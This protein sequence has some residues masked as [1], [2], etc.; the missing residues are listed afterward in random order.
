MKTSEVEK[1]ITNLYKKNDIWYEY[2]INDANGTI[3]ANIEIDWGDWKHDHAYIDYL[4]KKNGF[5]PI[6]ERITD[7]DGSDAY[8]SVHIYLY[9][10]K[11]KR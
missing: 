1:I 6:G 8:S 5:L 4:M 10:G 7:E 11:T 2:N 9:T 3:F